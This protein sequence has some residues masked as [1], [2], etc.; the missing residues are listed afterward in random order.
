MPDI[1]VKEL[2]IKKLF[3]LIHEIS[4]ENKISSVLEIGCGNG[5][6]INILSKS[7]NLNF[8]GID[9]NK[10]MIQ[11]CKKRK[12]KNVVFKNVNILQNKFKDDEFDLIYTERCLINLL[13]WKEQKQA[14]DIIHKILKKNGYFIM[15]EAFDDGL[16]TLNQA[17]KAIGL[18]KISAAWH[19]LY[20]SKTKLQQ[21]IKNKFTN[22]DYNKK[23]TYDNFLSTYYYGSRVLYP[24]LI[25]GK[26][27]I[28]YNNKFIEFFSMIPNVG[29]Y[30]P[31]QV[32]ILK[33][34]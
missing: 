19:N 30:S 31:I 23:I 17:R 5:Y 12:T 21:F 32:C 10:E 6:T 4:N 9:S 18:D 26:N 14:L 28:K 20:F 34:I 2:E 25:E 33:K 16:D 27:S 3:S 1:Y 13:S 29:N 15:I 24:S 11:L 8:F 22:Y 7:F